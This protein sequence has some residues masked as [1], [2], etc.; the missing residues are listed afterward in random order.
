MLIISLVSFNFPVSL[1]LAEGEDAGN[2]QTIEEPVLN[3]DTQ[4]ITGDVT[5]EIYVE[6]EVNTNITDI[7]SEATSTEVILT[8]A[9]STE[10][11]LSEATSTEITLTEATSTQA[12]STEIEVDNENEAVVENNIEGEGESGNNQVNNNSGN[13]LIDTGDVNLVVGLVNTVN[14]NITGS[15][16]SQFLFNIFENLEGDIDLSNE[17][18]TSSDY[19]CLSEACRLN[20][21]VENKN[22]GS[23]ENNVLINASS[24]SNFATTSEAAAII[25]TGNA[26]VSADV[27]NTLNSNIVGSN[28]TRIIINVFDNWIGDL[29]FPGKEAMRMFL[30]Q[31]PPDCR[32]GCGSFRIVNL[33][34][35]QIENGV[36]VTGDTGQNTTIAASSTIETGEA[37]VQTNLFNI[38]NTNITGGNWFFI[39]INNFGN[40]EGNILSLPPGFE[41]SEDFEGIKIYNLGPD[42]FNNSTSTD[43]NATTTGSLNI[44]NDNSGSIKN[45]IIVNVSTGGNSATSANGEARITTGNANVVANL[46]NILNSNISGNNWLSAMINIFGSWEGNL[47]FGQP[48]LLIAES[49]VTSSNPAEAGGTITY[50]LTYFNNGD[51]DATQATIV[52]NYDEVYLSVA[53]AGGGVVIDN[54]G[55]IRWDIGTI[56]VGGSGSVSYSVVINSAMPYGITYITNQSAV[57]SF[58]DDANNEDNFDTISV[59]V[60]RPFPVVSGAGYSSSHSSSSAS[61]KLEIKKTNNA[62][63]FVYTESKVDYKIVLYNNSSGS[64][65]NVVVKDN[66][67]NNDSSEVFNTQSWDLGEV[68]PYEEITIDYTVAIGSEVLAGFYTNTA[69]AIGLD[70]AGN[71]ISSPEATTTIEIR[72]LEVLSEEQ[73]E[74]KEEEVSLEEKE[75]PQENIITSLPEILIPEVLAQEIVPS[76][77]KPPVEAGVGGQEAAL[78][79]GFIPQT[80]FFLF[81]I[82]LFIYL[83]F[84]VY[85]I[86]NK[87]KTGPL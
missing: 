51:A 77:E 27:F 64:A 63:G 22:R 53:D 29:I 43:G 39:A 42:D 62:N 31:N 18:A 72:V 71:S 76:L 58:E 8:E 46:I 12:T 19:D 13:S 66:L 48:D 7:S 59:G 30:E 6:N 47:A 4:I 44:I 87:R 74:V 28:W 10:I 55:E 68:F 23:I 5:G 21:N 15:N 86:S 32:G 3:E 52:D 61:P 26:N 20:L 65:Y 24:G 70:S 16:F 9:T 50:T 79:L 36:F 1:V 41:I 57:D 83:V 82:I 37:N 25:K 35:G 34:E 85:Q 2:N 60:Y 67:I 11:S 78:I 14:T 49:A 45:S 17:I 84:I 40:W 33:N 38:A 73:E 56:P 80:Y 69:Q 81:L 54:P 75:V